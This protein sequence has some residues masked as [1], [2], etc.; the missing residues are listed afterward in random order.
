MTEVRV[1]TKI[2]QPTNT[3]IISHKT[4]LKHFKTPDMFRSCQIIIR[5]FSVLKCLKVVLCEI[6]CAFVS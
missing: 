2:Y 4:L 3:H 1:F 6:I 5:E